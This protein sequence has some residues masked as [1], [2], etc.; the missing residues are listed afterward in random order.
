MESMSVTTA[1]SRP[2]VAH[3]IHH[4]VTGGLENGLVN[5]I[6]QLPESRYRHVVVC[7]TGYSDFRLRIRRPDVEVIAMNK[8]PGLD[9]RTQRELVRLFRRLRPAIVHGRNLSALDALLPAAL[10]GVRIRIHGEHGRD[11]N[12][13]VGANP[14][15]I[16]LRRFYSPLV[17]HYVALNGDL[18]TYL[19]DRVGIRPARI[20]RIYNGVDLARFKADHVA[21]RALLPAAFRAPGCFVVGTVGQLRVVKDHA[22]L[23]R[24]FV[25]AVAADPQARQHMRLAIVGD[26]QCRA[27]VSG[28]LRQGGVE[29]LAWLAGDRSDVPQLLAAFDLFVLPSLAEGVSNT[30]LEAMATALPVLATRVGGNPELIE[31][32]ATGRLVASA[33]SEALAGAMLQYLHDPATVTQQ[34]NAGR[35]RV[36]TRFSL[37]RMVA[38]YDALYAQLLGRLSP[39]SSG[40]QT[41]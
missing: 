36:E 19:T 28:I 11:E 35:T 8:R 22:N 5:L 34:G 6:N 39:A 40:L 15:L 17:T 33:N 7:M 2:L 21:A 1:D 13:P 27:E 37:E 10:A 30:I 14:R 31:E 18:H 29:S 24:A 4:L 12:D 26:G 9:L 23:A 20:S 38:S 25:K 32:G 41:T 3:V 16:W